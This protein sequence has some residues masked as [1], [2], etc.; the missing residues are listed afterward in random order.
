M[1]SP[2]RRPAPSRRSP[3]LGEVEDWLWDRPSFRMIPDLKL[4]EAPY[5]EP[6]PAP[7]GALRVGFAGFPSDFSVALL[8]AL[9]GTGVELVGIATSLGANPAIAGENALSQI[10]EHFRVPLLR[11]ARV[12]DYDSLVELRRLRPQLMLVASFDQ[13]LRPRALAIPRRGWVNVHPSLLPRY[14]GPEP[15]YWAIVEGE[16]ESGISFQRVARG[17]DAGPLL[18]QRH[19]PIEDDD[20][21]GIL[22]RR[23]TR[24]GADAMPEAMELVAANAAGVEMDMATGSYFTSVGHRRIDRVESSLLADRMVRAGNPNMLAATECG[25][26]LCYVIRARRLPPSDP[27]PG[28]RLHFPDGDL[29]LE[30]TVDRCG[31]HHALP[32]G[33]CPHDEADPG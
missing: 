8:L 7:S 4:P 17:I 30:Q 6:Q 3:W 2:D 28:P 23:L 10:A 21:N 33:S 22:T 20:D 12:N 13:I 11:L 25:G 31:C 24:L 19:A 27:R 14:R 9:L 5:G 26:S 1:P 18:L 16:R 32:V 29:L 15:V